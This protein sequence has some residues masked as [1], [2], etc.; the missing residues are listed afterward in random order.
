ML[1]EDGF[2]NCPH[3]RSPA[4]EVVAPGGDDIWNSW[5]FRSYKLGRVRSSTGMR[6][7]N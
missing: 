3:G 1:R 5:K 4:A 2:R 6:I 7:R